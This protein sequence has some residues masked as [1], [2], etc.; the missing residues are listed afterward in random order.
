MI[1]MLTVHVKAEL[2][3][4]DVVISKAEEDESFASDVEIDDDKI[5]ISPVSID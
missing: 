4:F 5:Q 2:I 3:L 1:M